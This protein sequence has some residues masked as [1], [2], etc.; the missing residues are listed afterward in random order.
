MFNV[1]RKEFA[2][3][4]TENKR[5]RFEIVELKRKLREQ[6]NLLSFVMRLVEKQNA[7]NRLIREL[8]NRPVEEKEN[9]S[10]NAAKNVRDRVIMDSFIVA[11]GDDEDLYIMCRVCHNHG[12]TATRVEG[13]GMEFV[14]NGVTGLSLYNAMRGHWD[15][16]HKA[17]EN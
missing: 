16:H 6:G 12:F 4:Y 11:N 1:P 9:L 5:L 14:P 10:V 2:G 3:R 8:S 13:V 17:G 15:R 7:T